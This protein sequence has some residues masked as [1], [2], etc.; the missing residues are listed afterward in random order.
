MTSFIKFKKSTT[1]KAI[2]NPASIAYSDMVGSSTIVIYV[3]GIATPFNIIFEDETDRDSSF[4]M[5]EISLE[6]ADFE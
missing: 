5:L 6:A 2:Y 3:T 4:S 1:P